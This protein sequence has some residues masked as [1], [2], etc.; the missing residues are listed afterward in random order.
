MGGAPDRPGLTTEGSTAMRRTLVSLLDD[1]AVSSP[2]RDFVRTDHESV[3]YAA[4]AD[5][6]RRVAAGL[7][8][9]GLR[10]GDRVA[11]AAPNGAAWLEFLFGATRLGLVVV[12]L[13][14]RY[15]ESELEYM[16]TQSAARLVVAPAVADGVDMEELYRSLGPRVPT[17][18]HVRFLDR[19]AGRDSFAD[20]KARGDDAGEPGPDAADPA[21]ILY[22]SGT[23]GRP[24]GA[25]L[26]HRSILSSAEAQAERTAAGP[27]DV[28]LN[29]MPLNHVGGLTCSVATMLTAQGTIVMPPAYSPAGALR[30]L[31]SDRVTI[32]AG[33]PTMWSLMLSH[34]DFPAV[35]ASSLRLG[36]I[37]GSNAEPALCDAITAAFPRARLTNLY[38]LTEVSGAVVLSAVE[39][40]PSVVSRTLGTPLRGVEVR[41]VDSDGRVVGPDTDGELQVRG[42]SVVNGY[43]EMPEETREVF[44]DGG[45]LATGD[46]VTRSETGH[47]R[48]RGR[49]K[50]M[51][52]QGGY[53]VYPVEVEN[54]LTRLPEVAMAAGVGV[55]DPVLGEV[56]LYFVV[57]R[58]PAAGLDVDGLLAHCRR[59]LADYKVPRRVEIV[60]ELPL[61]PSGKVAKAEL[62][63]RAAGRLAAGG[64]HRTVTTELN[65]PA[66][67]GKTRR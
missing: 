45:W 53:N 64:G 43:W 67:G 33:V 17:L 61:T 9:L 28:M 36:I 22:T 27:A 42:A 48:L 11:V 49:R 5:R 56:G 26:T 39:D 66:R 1:A 60:A 31:H 57:P 6:S 62:R 24:K 65:D 14:V 4:M 38:G 41:V 58:D 8:E 63:D 7:A 21:V 35:D 15:R 51:F 34:A 40:P 3:T 54:V 55:P 29:V 19:D 44:L 18:E 2:E 13:N 32:F 52:L 47:L 37:G 20:L 25:V 23:T 46:I 50:E 16:L 59:Q 10:H 30:S 12:T